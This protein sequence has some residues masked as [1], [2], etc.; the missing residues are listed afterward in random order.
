MKILFVYPKYPDIF[1]SFKYAFTS[2]S[3]MA[4]H[5]PLGLLNVA[6]MLP[7]E[8]EQ[9][10]VDMSTN[11][12]EDKHLQWADYIFIDTMAVQGKSVKEVIA[13]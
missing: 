5:P 12:L 4:V 11:V 2:I 8:W 9:K 7:G 13:R 1:W 6:A 10:L 3:K